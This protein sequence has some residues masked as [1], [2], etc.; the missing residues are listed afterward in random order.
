MI[1]WSKAVKPRMPSILNRLLPM[2]LPSAMS[3]SP[4]N[5]AAIA[6][7]GVVGVDLDAALDEEVALGLDGCVAEPELQ[8]RRHRLQRDAGAGDQRFEQHIARAELEPRAA[9]AAHEIAE[10]ILDAV[11]GAVSTADRP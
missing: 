4:L 10:G 8:R 7:A 1:G 3:V 9:N 6:V 2:T 11:F 5:A